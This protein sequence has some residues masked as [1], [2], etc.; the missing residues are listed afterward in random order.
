MIKML[1]KKFNVLFL[2]SA[3]EA[4]DTL[5]E[6]LKAHCVQDISHPGGPFPTPHIHVPI[7]LEFCSSQT[8][9]TSSTANHQETAIAN[10]AYFPSKLFALEIIFS[11]SPHYRPIKSTEIPFLASPCD[12]SEKASCDDGCRDPPPVTEHCSILRCGKSS[13]CFAISTTL[14]AAEYHTITSFLFSCV[15]IVYPLFARCQPQ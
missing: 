11:L 4:V 3:M 12:I 15:S 9:Q 5:S 6:Y 14:T 7:R 8:E 2:V 1:L 13:E 10:T